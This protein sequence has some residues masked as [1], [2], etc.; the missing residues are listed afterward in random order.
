MEARSG[1]LHDSARHCR[2][3]Y[4]VF[5]FSAQMAPQSSSPHPTD[6]FVGF[7][8]FD[9]LREAALH[10]AGRPLVHLALAVVGATHDVLDALLPKQQIKKD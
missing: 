9:E 5:D 2:N 10:D 7:A 6:V 4:S 3:K 8:L 1:F